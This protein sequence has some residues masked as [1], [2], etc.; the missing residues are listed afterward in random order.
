MNKIKP[1]RGSVPTLPAFLDR[2]VHHLFPAHRERPAVTGLM[3][4]DD[5]DKSSDTTE[6]ELIISAKRI[7]VRKAPGPDG[8]PGL[9]IKAA[10]LNTPIL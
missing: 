4:N 9:A 1:T 10:A 7:C 2:V 3:A 6:A 5:A 8:I